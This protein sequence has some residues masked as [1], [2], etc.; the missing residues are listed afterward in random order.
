MR[1]NTREGREKDDR[2][3]KSRPT[4]TAG[5]CLATH[6][7][8]AFWI[9]SGFS[10][11]GVFLSKRTENIVRD[12]V[13]NGMQRISNR[14]SSRQYD[15]H[16]AT[17]SGK[18][19]VYSTRPT[20]ERFLFK[21]TSAGRDARSRPIG[22]PTFEVIAIIAITAFLLLFFFRFTPSRRTNTSQGSHIVHLTSRIP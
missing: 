19:R 11:M 2:S 16:A 20:D 9:F 18:Q 7:S 4:S 22:R 21:L 8:Y 15:V 12:G 6:T 10:L 17:A 14:E 1:G 5:A 3:T 13:R